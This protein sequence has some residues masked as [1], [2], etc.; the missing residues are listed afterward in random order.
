MIVKI[1][2]E[3]RKKKRLNLTLFRYSVFNQMRIVIIIIWFWSV[4]GYRSIDYAFLLLIY[5]Y[6]FIHRK[7]E[8]LV[9]I[10]SL[11]FVVE[12]IYTIR[13]K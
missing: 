6:L 7:S 11:G 3:K 5:Y 1:E 9:F 13:F 2:K 4:N 12:I 8:F 10:E